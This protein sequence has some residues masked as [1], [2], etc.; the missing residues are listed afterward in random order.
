M[1]RLHK[2]DNI[3]ANFK[4]GRNGGS[5]VLDV[6][7]STLNNTQIDQLKSLTKATSQ[8]QN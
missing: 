6:I 1:K 7:N 8:C 3:K 2:I 5:I 4:S